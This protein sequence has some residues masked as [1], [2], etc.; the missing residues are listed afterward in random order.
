MCEMVPCTIFSQGINTM[1]VGES[2][3]ARRS[4]HCLVRPDFLNCRPLISF[5]YLHS[6]LLTT[7]HHPVQIDTQKTV[8][9]LLDHR[10]R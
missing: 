8:P 6:S 9:T 10:S 4:F 3:E 7:S 1:F 2:S 5:P